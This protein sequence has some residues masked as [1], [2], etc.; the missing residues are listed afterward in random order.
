MTAKRKSGLLKWSVLL[1][2][3]VCAYVGWKWYSGKSKTTTVEYKNVPVS[4]GD[5]TQTV[6]ANGQLSPVKSVTVGSQVSGIIVDINVD[7][8]STVTNGQVLAQ[9]DPSTYKQNL[10]QAEAELA[11]TMATLEHAQLNYKRAKELRAN[12]LISQSDFETT[13]VE[14]HQ[15][16]ATVKMREASVNNAKVNLERTTI[17]SPIDG[18]VISRAVD[19]GQTVAA[20]FNT[21]TLFNIAN[22]LRQMR[23]EAAISEADV[24]GVSEGQPVQFTVDAYPNRQFRGKVTQVRYAAITNQNVV[25]YVSIVEVSNDDLKLR[26]GMTASASIITA[27]KKGAL[28]IPNSA[29]RFRPPES[30]ALSGNTN[31]AA[32]TGTAGKAPSAVASATAADVRSSGSQSDFAQLSPEE[33]RKRMESMTPEERERMRAAR[34]SRSGE[35]SGPGS[36]GMDGGN[37]DAPL[38]RTVY[39]LET[40][41]FNPK[42]ILKPVSIKTGIS[43][44]SYTEVLEGLNEGDVLVTGINQST[45]KSTTTQ[46]GTS[47]FAPQRPR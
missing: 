42:G 3:V 37:P 9:I 4:R 2:L 12:D 41:S 23:I 39:L 19:A 31:N 17:Y 22:D 38:T 40:N 18:V 15:A 6:T 14:L 34:R 21:P 11:S 25:N 13:E 45:L 28:R 10:T 20:S 16:Q 47:P 5:I 30:S 7:F 1:A 36:H 33:R 26:P 46:T 43:D 29:L 35:A 44:N 8:N 27:Q 32:S 24:G